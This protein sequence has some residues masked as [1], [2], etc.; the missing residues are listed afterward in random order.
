M[1]I[2]TLALVVALA[3]C[4]PNRCPVFIGQEVQDRG[5][6]KR[7]VIGAIDPSGGWTSACVVGVRWSDGTNSK[8]EAWTLGQ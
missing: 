2:L 8:V 5:A 4:I 1:K 3:G 7:G 6:G